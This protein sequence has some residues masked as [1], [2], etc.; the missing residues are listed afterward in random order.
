[1]FLFNDLGSFSSKIASSSLGAFEKGICAHKQ[2]FTANLKAQQ[3]AT[4]ALA[5]KFIFIFF[6]ISQQ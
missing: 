1:M 5:L 4:N 6:R 2:E 3:E